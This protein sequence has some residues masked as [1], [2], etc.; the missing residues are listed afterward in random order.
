LV[1]DDG[2]GVS[3]TPGAVPIT[4]VTTAEGFVSGE[5]G[6]QTMISFTDA[7]GTYTDLSF[8][9]GT[10]ANV[11]GNASI[12]HGTG[13]TA[14]ASGLE[15]ITD[16]RL[17]T[18]ILNPLE[19]V[20]YE[21]GANLR[22]TDKIFVI[23]N[24]AGASSIQAVDNLGNLIGSPVSVTG[25]RGSIGTFDY[26]RNDG[27][28]APLPDRALGGFAV[29][30]ADLGVSDA[31]TIAGVRLS[32]SGG[33]YNLI[34]FASLPVGQNTDQ[35]PNTLSID[36]LAIANAESIVRQN[37]I[38]E[39]TSADSL[40]FRVTFDSDVQNVSLDDFDV[41]GTTA[42]VTGVSQ[43]SAS[44]YDVTVSGG[45]LAGFDGV[46]GLSFAA[47]QDIQSAGYGNSPIDG[48]LPATVETYTVDNTVP[49]P[50]VTG[51]GAVE[52]SN[53]F[54]VTIDFGETVTGFTSGDIIVGGGSVTGFTDNLDGTFTVEITAAGEGNV[55]VDVVSSAATD[56]AGNDSPSTQLVTEVDALA[57][58]PVIT[59]PA[60]VN[61]G[62]TA[63]ITVDF[64]EDVTGFDPADI[65]DLPVVN[66]SVTGWT[67]LGGGA[68]EVQ[69]LPD[70]TDPVVIG[71]GADAANSTAGNLRGNEPSSVLIIAVN[72]GLSSEDLVGISNLFNNFGTQKLFGDKINV[73]AQVV[74]SDGG[75]VGL[76][77][78]AP[79]ATAFIGDPG[80]LF[81][82]YQLYTVTLRIE[83]SEGDDILSIV[84][85]TVNG[86]NLN[87]YLSV[88]GDVLKLVVSRL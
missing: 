12:L 31:S 62:S 6:S 66:G 58:V 1:V 85:A 37:P 42:T 4:A 25:A 21:F 9:T 39:F 23:Q 49:T 87:P 24:D 84:A 8:V 80:S 63:V 3:P 75:L 53:P 77:P 26:L 10:S 17:D 59:G 11:P 82:D 29:E 35:T 34:G 47:G 70:G 5:G 79:G 30:V 60:T 15:A 56:R 54:P 71:V 51:A 33:D 18:A 32:G 64:E 28:A 45:D 68:Y 88:A 20:N 41:T 48:T 14:P 22:N 2:L 19:T 73:S 81:D 61:Q 52:T 44:E 72:G 27:A 40:V 76:V 69:V 57:P 16:D 50:T 67:P 7:G 13:T 74:D 86:S 36:V 65:L 46:A 83:M 38:D 78:I 55:S 43:V